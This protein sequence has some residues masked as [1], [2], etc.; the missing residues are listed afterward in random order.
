[1]ISLTSLL[2]NFPLTPELTSE[3]LSLPRHA[4]LRNGTDADTIPALVSTWPQ[5]NRSV[6]N[7]AAF[8]AFSAHSAITHMRTQDATMAMI[9]TLKMPMSA[10][11]LLMGT[12]RLS[13]VGMGMPMMSTSVKRFTAPVNI[14]SLDGS[15]HVTFFSG[16]LPVLTPNCARYPEV[17]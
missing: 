8:T 9:P 5:S 7:L 11:L 6:P 4:S 13:S 16:S 10:S 14:H 3:L 15:K 2:P 17:S 12:R 1:M